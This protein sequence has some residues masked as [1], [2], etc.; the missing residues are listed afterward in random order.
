MPDIPLSGNEQAKDVIREAVLTEYRQSMDFFYFRL[1]EL[2]TNLYIV[3][4]VLHFPRELLFGEGPENNIFFGQ[5]VNNA[6]QVSILLITKLTKDQG[7]DVR[8]LIRFKNKVLDMVKPEYTKAFQERLKTMKFDQKT[9]SLLEKVS[10]LRDTRIAHFTD[11]FFQEYNDPTK[12]QES[13]IFSE[14]LVL[15]DELNALL[16][17]L[18][19]GI[20]HGTLPASYETGNS[21][22]KD[23]LNCLAQTSYLLNM[24]ESHPDWWQ[25]ERVR[26]TKSQLEQLNFY[27]RRFNLPEI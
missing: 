16:H 21:D 8:T 13:V 26:L 7:R 22:I 11:T 24:P 15:R 10:R 17:A 4:Q 20:K 6:L 25:Q 9:Q 1:V 5:T 23:I 14:I 19:F 18:S 12:K 3:E 27:R 2:N